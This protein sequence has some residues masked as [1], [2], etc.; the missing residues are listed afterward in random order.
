MRGGAAALTLEG[1]DNSGKGMQLSLASIAPWGR[2]TTIPDALSLPCSVTRG[3]S[4]DAGKSCPPFERGKL[5]VLPERRP[6]FSQALNPK[7]EN[8]SPRL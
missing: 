7:P 3:I 8:L 2:T 5:Q 4:R 6:V 1:D